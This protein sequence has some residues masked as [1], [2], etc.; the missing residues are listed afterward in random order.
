MIGNTLRRVTKHVPTPFSTSR[1]RA[2]ANK[3]N[4]VD[5]DLDAEMAAVIPVYLIAILYIFIDPTVYE[6]LDSFMNNVIWEKDYIVLSYAAIIALLCLGAIVVNRDRSLRDTKG[7]D[8][9]IVWLTTALILAPV[10]PI[11]LDGVITGAPV[12]IIALVSALLGIMVAS[13]MN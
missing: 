9:W 5:L 7:I 13:A 10:S 1:V 6:P 11:I 2:R 8:V 12:N 4:G 3:Y